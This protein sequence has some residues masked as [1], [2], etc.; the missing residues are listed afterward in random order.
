[1]GHHRTANVP[2][3]F[4]AHR[5][6][7]AAA[8]T[9]A[10]VRRSMSCIQEQPTEGVRPNAG[11]MARSDPR[12]SV[13][14]TQGA[15]SGQ[16]LAS[17]LQEGRENANIGAGLGFIWRISVKS[18]R[19]VEGLPHMR[20]KALHGRDA[21][22]IDM[23]LPLR[24]MND[25]GGKVSFRVGDDAVDEVA[26]VDAREKFHVEGRAIHRLFVQDLV[27]PDKSVHITITFSEY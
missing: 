10:S 19:H 13:R 2:R 7:T 6:A 16:H 26:P 5:G 25:D 1:R 18:S 12:P 8:T 15:G 3:D 27:I 22:A 17:V 24:A 23:P 14:V 20:E 9:S 4:A 21:N 11:K